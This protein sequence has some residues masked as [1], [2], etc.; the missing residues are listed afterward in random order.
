MD[1]ALANKMDFYLSSSD[2]NVSGA[3]RAIIAITYCWI[4]QTNFG[5]APHAAHIGIFYLSLGRT[6]YNAQNKRKPGSAGLIAH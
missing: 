1:Y 3:H 6:A 5:A 4:K 2:G